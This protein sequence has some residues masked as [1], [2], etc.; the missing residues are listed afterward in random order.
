[1][2]S[3][4]GRREGYISLEQGSVFNERPEM[5]SS[6]CFGNVLL[7]GTT[8]L[9]GGRGEGAAAREVCS[10]RSWAQEPSIEPRQAPGHFLEYVISDELWF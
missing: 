2:N 5:S 10:M 6:S 9:N 7:D 3:L 1:M 8:G 4:R